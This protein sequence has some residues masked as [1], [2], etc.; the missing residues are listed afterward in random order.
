[1]LGQDAASE[2]T[3]PSVGWS[4]RRLESS[5]VLGSQAGQRRSAVGS[6]WTDALHPVGGLCPGADRVSP[7]ARG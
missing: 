7:R 4:G 2:Y 5:R 3:R 6:S 1:V